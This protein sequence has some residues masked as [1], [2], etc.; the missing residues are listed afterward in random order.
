MPFTHPPEPCEAHFIM[1]ECDLFDL[2]NMTVE[3]T[4]PP[5]PK[6]AQPL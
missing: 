6:K 2:F 3:N 4:P 5:P 1:Y